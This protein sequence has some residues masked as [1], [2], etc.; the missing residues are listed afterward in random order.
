M[1]GIT[2][3]LTRILAPLYVWTGE[4]FLFPVNI[5]K[6]VYSHVKILKF[7]SFNHLFQSS[8]DDDDKDGDDD[9]DDDDYHVND[10][11]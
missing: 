4:K 7:L 8:N 1:F 3:L 6:Y 11:G 10:N 9:D 5:W 2:S